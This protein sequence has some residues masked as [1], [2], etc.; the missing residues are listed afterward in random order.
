MSDLRAA[1][2]RC[3]RAALDAGALAP[4]PTRLHEVE[5][6]GI[7][8]AVR[9]AAAREARPRLAREGR[10]AGTNPFLPYE[11]ALFVGDVGEH[12]V[13]LLNKYPVLP[14]HALLVTRAYE[15]QEAPLTRSDC[16]ALW[17]GLEALG[18]LG[19]F[20]AGARAGASLPHR[21][22][23]VVPTPLGRGPRAT[24]ID[25]LLDDARFDDAVGRC[26]ALPFHHAIARLRHLGGPDAPSPPEAA[27]TLHALYREMARAFGCDRPGR[28]HNL[29]VTREW[30]LLVP[31]SRESWEGVSLNALA[32]AGAILVRDD[33]TLDRVRSLGP[34][35]LLAH[36]GVPR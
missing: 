11:Q 6:G 24:P 28:P 8:F 34:L 10:R 26:E 2:R 22:L 19:F 14:G 16:E 35:N 9:V 12:H 30:M 31:R 4:I 15:D 7:R 20:N 33:P 13:C 17:V 1:L 29:L 21:H 18:G 36:V 5:D 25:P 32:F 3:E 23:Q 27:A